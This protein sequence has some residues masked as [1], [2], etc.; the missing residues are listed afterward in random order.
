MEG[1]QMQEAKSTQADEIRALKHMKDREIDTTEIP[2]VLDGARRLSAS[3]IGQP[4]NR[5]GIS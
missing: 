2:P 5:S 4:R 1:E 3:S